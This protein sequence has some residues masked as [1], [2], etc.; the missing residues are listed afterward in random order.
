MFNSVRQRWRDARRS[1]LPL[2]SY[3]RRLIWLCMLPLVGLAVY[4]AFDSVSR[5]RQADADAGARL[6]KQIAATVD[7]GLRARM[8]ALR[9]L[10][11]SPLLDDTARLAE[12][13]REAQGFRRTY[14]SEVIL[15]SAEGQM[16]LHSAQAPGSP[17]PVLPQPAG[18]GAAQATLLSGRPEVGDLV[19]GPIAKVPLIAI[20]TVVQRAAL[21]TRL[22][23][24]P[25]PARQFQRVL[26]DV[27]L[28]EG[29]S[30]VLL[31]SRK[32]TVASRSSITPN[33]VSDRPGEQFFIPSNASHWTVVLR[34]AQE[35]R[36]APL[37]RAA[38]ALAIAILG[39]TLTGLLAGTLAS[40]RLARSVAALAEVNPPEAAPQIAEVAAARKLLDETAADRDQA[41]AAVQQS[42]AA[43]LAIFDGLPDAA[44]LT[45]PNR[46]IR[47]VN[48]AFTRIFGYTADEVVGRTAEL[49]YATVDD[50]TQVG[51]RFHESDAEAREVYEMR[52]RRRD[53]TVFWGESMG[54]RI[55][56]ADGSTAALFGL[57][58][59]VSARKRAEEVLRKS[60]AQLRL[61]IQQAPLSIAM[62]DRS[63]NYL[64]ASAGWQVDNG[65]GHADLTGLNHYQVNPD[66][67]AE[68]REIYEQAL[69][70]RAQSREV[71]RWVQADGAEM[72]RR[73]AVVPWTDEDGAVG[74]I[75]ISSEDIT[76]Q[77]QARRELERQQ[78]KLEA[79]V[80]QRTADLEAANATLAQRAA[81][82]A[83]LYDH[84]PCG[85]FSIAPDRTVVEINETALHLLQHRRDEV[86]GRAIAEF[87]APES[88][89]LFA[90]RFIDF[91]RDGEVRDLEYD[92]VRK[93]GSI[94]PVLVSAVMVRN[95]DGAFVRSRATLVDNSERKLRAREIA[96]M[97]VEL[98][99]RADLAEAANRAKSAFLANMSHE[100]RTP[101]NA[102]IG[103]TH[104]I[105]R[106]AHDAL[107]R[108]RLAKV[109][110]AAR[111]LLQVINDILDISK[112]EAGKM[113]LEE[114]DFLLDRLLTRTFD[115]VG[116]RAR[117][118]GLELVVD[119]D[120]LPNALRGDPTR[121]SQALLNLLSNAVKFTEQGWVQVRGS[122]LRMDG[123]RLLVRFEVRDTGEGIPPDRQATLF[124]AFEQ[125]DSSTTR[126]HGGTGLGLALTRYIATMMGGEV[127]VHSAPG[128]GSTFW[129]TA[130]LA[131]AADIVEPTPVTNLRG[132]RALLVDDLPEARVAIAD[133][134]RASG[135]EVDVYDSG[136]AALRAVNVA[137]AAA[138]PY[139]VF[140]VDW[141]MDPL[142]GIETLRRMRA[143][144]GSAMPPSI[145]VTAHDEPL[146]W[147]Q[148]RGVLCD[149]V[150]IKPITAS[151]LVEA[152]ERVLREPKRGLPST[153]PVPGEAEAQLRRRNAGQRVLLVE[154]NPINQE[155]ALELL[156]SV[157]LVADTADDGERAVELAVSRSYDAILM[158]VQMPG[159]D[160]L[161]ATRV[162]R[163]RMGNATPVIAMTANAFNEDR[164]ACLEAGMNDHVAKPVDPEVLF[165][166]LLRWLPAPPPA[167]APPSP[168]AA[169]DDEHRDLPLADRLADLEGFDI[170][171]A[172]RNVGG[173][174]GVLERALV[175][176][177]ATYRRG[178][179]LFLEAMGSADFACWPAVAHSLRG[180]CAAV[181]AT[182][183]HNALAE[184][185]RVLK[186]VPDPRTLA[187]QARRLHEDLLVLVERIDHELER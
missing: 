175:R 47:R 131:R 185:E 133:R 164:A 16:L 78:E 147:Q 95:A 52:Y 32:D 168:T 146:M 50:F 44:V 30:V 59:D 137:L 157:G 145:L 37:K 93:D 5:I 165:A 178:A 176:F 10:A 108:T 155:V 172:L 48:P 65:R 1:Q 68:W 79:L 124:D 33:A 85:Y 71:D 6:A 56:A 180:A 70:G 150:L 187:P 87:M 73:W 103:L 38:L 183:L 170:D 88:R 62:F 61:F 114:T 107:Q 80:A 76:P 104:L 163:Q 66:L 86:V 171:Q 41:A 35:S 42:E 9:L 25:V 113:V 134:L 173:N 46:S 63:M 91:L 166:T 121:L 116:E 72:W 29:W 136:A 151:T 148:A 77:Q 22:L 181:G 96:A 141:R 18:R 120:H 34:N 97:Q 154:D 174:L 74:G 20:A 101:M 67:P 13:H 92:F 111:H 139:D 140:L 60:Q 43:F 126:R 177:V 8:D 182:Q 138:R 119:T 2:Q 159:M 58:R 84:A 53:G 135:V 90:E 160:G 11:E 100:I 106:D 21:P 184:F 129:F 39:A 57:H 186:T 26:D 27:A 161:A 158:D 167:G 102:I 81:A 130:W 15:A 24:T 117:D 132:R 112:I 19:L 14:G 109:D 7:Q 153:P 40:R 94:L 89:T 127:G 64:A 83:D 142:D 110:G 4:L 55:A 36:E 49:L 31:D 98:A 123:R 115:L 156:T 17:L 23:L 82:I 125:A 54:L 12:F 51:R 105:A 128:E 144:L 75:I 143:L 149:A 99:R 169:R 45:Y 152:I 69:A 118:K 28:P 122:L 179:P 3:L 162:I